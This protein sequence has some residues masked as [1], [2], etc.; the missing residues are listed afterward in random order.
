MAGNLHLHFNPKNDFI[1]FA[2]ASYVMQRAAEFVR[3]HSADGQALPLF[4]CGDYNSIPVSSVM[5]VFH[6]EDIEDQNNS[7]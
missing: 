6:N 2:Q 3:K 1:K 4:I 7:N 5:S